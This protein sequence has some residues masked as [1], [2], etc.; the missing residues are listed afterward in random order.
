MGERDK[1]PITLTWTAPL[2]EGAGVIAYLLYKVVSPGPLT[3]VNTLTIV[4]GN[5]F[6][7]DDYDYNRRLL[8]ETGYLYKVTALNQD[9]ESDFSLSNEVLI[10]HSFEDFLKLEEWEFAF[11]GNDIL[12]LF[13]DW[14]IT[15][16]S[17]PTEEYVERWEP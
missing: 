4:N 2:E 3:P 8:E 10:T 6:L 11:T 7:Y 5:V 14:N 1:M 17:I 13:E 9:G 16:P 12:E 15:L